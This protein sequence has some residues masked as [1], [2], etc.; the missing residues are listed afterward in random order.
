MSEDNTTTP[1]S[2]SHQL[3]APGPGFDRTGIIEQVIEQI[4]AKHANTMSTI[5][6][7]MENQQ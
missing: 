4:S 3:Q 6:N 1:S 2:E 5:V 7:T